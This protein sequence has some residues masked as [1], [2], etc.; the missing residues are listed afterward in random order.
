MGDD[1]QPDLEEARR[2]VDDFLATEGAGSLAP[3]R[4]RCLA[5]TV[6]RRPAFSACVD[7]VERKLVKGHAR[8]DVALA[9]AM[10]GMAPPR[11]SETIG[12]SWPDYRDRAA[13]YVGE[14]PYRSDTDRLAYDVVLAGTLRGVSW[15]AAWEVPRHCLAEVVRAC[16]TRLEGERGVDLELGSIPRSPSVAHLAF[17]LGGLLVSGNCNCGGSGPHAL[18]DR[19]DEHFLGAWDPGSIT[20]AGFVQRAVGGPWDDR[21]AAALTDRPRT[22]GA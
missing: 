17:R 1:H 9:T 16:L 15:S 12:L 13:K 19:V 10:A 2:L 8:L 7:T 4:A 14:G 18:C 22:L 5:G 3:A 20:L 11:V 21:S 6:G